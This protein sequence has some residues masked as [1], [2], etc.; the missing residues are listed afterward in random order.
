MWSDYSSRTRFTSGENL[1]SAALANNYAGHSRGD[2]VSRVSSF[3]SLSLFLSFSP[4]PAR[5]VVLSRSYYTSSIALIALFIVSGHVWRSRLADSETQ[6]DISESGGY[7]R[8]HLWVFRVGVHAPLIC[9]CLQRIATSFL[10]P[11]FFLI[12]AVCRPTLSPP[13]TSLSLGSFSILTGERDPCLDFEELWFQSFGFS[14][15]Q[16]YRGRRE[17]IT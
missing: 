13:V 17:R 2:Y 14:S 15:I 3:V 1:C 10:L 16:S 6:R 12:S 9:A 11:P 7:T 5:D 8:V 4:T